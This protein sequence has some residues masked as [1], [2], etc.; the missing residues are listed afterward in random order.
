MENSII[1]QLKK[2]SIQELEEGI[3]T[4]KE[5]QFNKCIINWL[6]LNN[7]KIGDEVYFAKNEHIYKGILDKVGSSFTHSHD[8]V[9]FLKNVGEVWSVSRY[10]I[11]IPEHILEKEIIK[12][13]KNINR[14]YFSLHASL[15]FTTINLAEI[16][17]KIMTF[18]SEKILKEHRSV[19]AIKKNEICRNILKTNYDLSEIEK[20]KYIEI[21]SYG[22]ID[23][24]Y[25]YTKDWRTKTFLIDTGEE[26]EK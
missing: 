19:F 13:N 6:K 3:K 18:A 16:E 26:I 7:L 22:G 10:F 4:K 15:F 14:S 5:E 1:N 2:Y 8:F 23:V 11:N 9:I 25:E 21:P 24:L 17:F 12:R 20:P